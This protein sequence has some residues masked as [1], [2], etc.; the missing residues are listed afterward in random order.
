MRRNRNAVL[1]I[2]YRLRVSAR[3]RYLI[4]QRGNT[5]RSRRGKSA[6]VESRR[7]RND[8]RSGRLRGN[9]YH[10]RN[11]AYIK[12]TQ[13]SFTAQIKPAVGRND[14]PAE[15]G[16]KRSQEAHRNHVALVIVRPEILGLHDVGDA[17]DVL[18]PL[19]DVLGA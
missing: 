8:K 14:F 1:K 17:V 13:I 19:V 18:E 6:R 10:G 16:C 4:A 7:I 12:S 3:E 15:S 11:S 2:G 9:K 5:D